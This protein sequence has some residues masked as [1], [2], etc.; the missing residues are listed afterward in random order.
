M[1]PSPLFWGPI[2]STIQIN[3]VDR[4]LDGRQQVLRDDMAHESAQATQTIF[5]REARKAISF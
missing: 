3:V 4:V 5:H 1:R 2:W